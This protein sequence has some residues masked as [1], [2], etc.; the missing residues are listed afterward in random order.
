MD[1]FNKQNSI[2]IRLNKLELPVYYR[3]LL[4]TG[5]RTNEARWLRRSDVD[6]TEGVVNINQSKGADQHRVALH[7]SML[8][9]LK[10]YDEN[11]ANY[12]NGASS[13]PNPRSQ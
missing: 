11:M 7:E 6:L 9:L 12:P 3:L 8:I 13:Y 4:S 1:A 10:R 2:A 5:M